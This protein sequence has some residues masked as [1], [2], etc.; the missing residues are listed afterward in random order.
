MK[1]GLAGFP[2][3][4]KDDQRDDV[5]DDPDQG[6]GKDDVTKGWC[7]HGDQQVCCGM[8]PDSLLS[9][10]TTVVCALSLIFFPI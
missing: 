8:F 10:Y 4:A 2:A 5:D 1:K 7:S 9:F 6:H 3:A